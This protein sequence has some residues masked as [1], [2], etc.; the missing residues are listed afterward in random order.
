LDELACIKKLEPS[1]SKFSKGTQKE[2][3]FN[4]LFVCLVGLGSASALPLEL[5]LS[6]F[7]SGC[8]GDDVSLTTRLAGLPSSQDYRDEP[9]VP[10]TANVY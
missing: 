2:D 5:C 1:K 9:P 3:T 8:F 4:F 10:G 6:S 7:C